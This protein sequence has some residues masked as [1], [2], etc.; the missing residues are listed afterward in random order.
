[1][2][3]LNR[4]GFTL[5]ELLAVV[6]ILAVILVVT[7]P[8]VLNTMDTAKQKSFDDAIEVIRDYAQKQYDLC[9]LNLSHDDLFDTNSCTFKAGTDLITKA[10][11]NTSDIS[12]ITV[13]VTGNKVSIEC[14]TAT[15]TNFKQGTTVG[16][17]QQPQSPGGNQPQDNG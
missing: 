16:V 12:A 7:I 1:M 5:I 11:Y 4:K 17:C 10:G 6:V 8:S 2:K 9:Q 14:A 15:G 3:K 13:T